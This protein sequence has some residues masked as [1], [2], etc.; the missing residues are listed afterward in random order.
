MCGSH[1]LFQIEFLEVQA[2]EKCDNPIIVGWILKKP[3]ELYQVGSCSLKNLI[4]HKTNSGHR[5]KIFQ[6]PLYGQA[7]SLDYFFHF[8]PPT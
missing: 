4:V 5:E 7:S 1:T 3:T 2:V 8:P 6:W